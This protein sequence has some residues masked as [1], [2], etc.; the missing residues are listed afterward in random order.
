MKLTGSNKSGRHLLKNRLGKK[1]SDGAATEEKNNKGKSRRPKHLIKIIV[2]SI[3]VIAIAAVTVVAL[4]LFTDSE[5]I[6][7]PP[8]VNFDPRP[9][10]PQPSDNPG[11]TTQVP[12]DPAAPGIA[13]S[14]D[15]IRRAGVYTFLIFGLDE[16]ENADVIMTATFDTVNHSLYVLSIPRDTLVNTEWNLKK[17]N[18]I[19]PNLWARHRSEPDRNKREA[20][21]MADAIERF[22]DVLGFEVDF[23]VS[24][25]MRAF[26]TLIDAVG[27]IDFYVP[28][29]M[30]YTDNAANLRINFRRGMHYGLTGQQALE[31]IRFRSF[32]NADIGRI[33][34]Q[35]QLLTAAVTQILDNRASFGTLTNIARL[36]DIAINQVRT[37]L[38]LTTMAW[39]GRA[40]MQ[41]E[42]ENIHFITLPVN[43]MDS[44]NRISYPT[45]LLDQ[46]LEIL[47]E[48]ISP[49]IS[50]K[51]IEDLSI[52]TRDPDRRL[53]VTD[54]NWRGNPTWGSTSR[55][56]AP[57]APAASG[58][59]APSGG[60]RTTPS[61]GGGGAT[62]APSGG[63]TSAPANQ[64]P[65]N[66]TPAPSTPNIDTN[67]EIDETDD[68]NGIE[69]IENID[70]NDII[71]EIV[72]EGTATTDEPD[73]AGVQDYD[74]V[75][76][77]EDQTNQSEPSVFSEHLETP[78]QPDLSQQ[79]PQT[80]AQPEGND[81][82]PAAANP[83]PYPVTQP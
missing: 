49:L 22:A 57:P 81:V 83:Y 64:T 66:Q 27:G 4:D 73:S 41:L 38:P 18:A 79:Q 74:T 44:V 10:R 78:A 33:N 50:D 70:D 15:G 35:Q 58:S 26:T 24:L 59:T 20:L 75:V 48:H 28:V 29:N 63:G 52:L 80:Q 8:D 67:D 21:V 7:Q 30:N 65:A 17:A 12:V 56:P 3:A 25:D 76:N 51:T 43:A 47:N 16:G 40:F 55:G 60:N 13:F 69:D 5:I 32:A 62:T 36:A 34:I 31:I 19:L 1:S 39:F 72:D 71:N 42:A 61:G 14:G 46:W 68:N 53:F 2:L 77:G 9:N 11:N 6:F 54:G 23:W 37:N 45:I 82:E